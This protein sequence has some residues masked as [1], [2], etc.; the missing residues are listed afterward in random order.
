VNG[1]R[2]RRPCWTQAGFPIVE[3]PWAYWLIRIGL[4]APSAFGS[5]VSPL[6][7]V[8]RLSTREGWCS[9]HV[10]ATSAIDQILYQ[11]PHS[12]PGETTTCPS[13]WDS[14]KD[15]RIS[16]GP[17][18]PSHILFEKTKVPRKTPLAGCQ[19]GASVPTGRRAWQLRPRPLHPLAALT[20]WLYP[21]Q[22]DRRSEITRLPWGT[23]NHC[24]QTG[25]VTGDLDRR[26]NRIVID[27]DGPL[28][29]PSS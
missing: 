27:E 16:A 11:R 7:E 3:P 22:T 28:C 29:G 6:E 2:G 20:V 14:R 12:V 8:W 21:R 17:W 19:R 9:L 23:S 24:L 15:C 10:Q 5:Q 1:T 25:I 26:R 18:I 4:A 13:L